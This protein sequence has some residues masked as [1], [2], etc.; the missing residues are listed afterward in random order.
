MSP[1]CAV[2]TL[3]LNPAVDL[4][5]SIPR[6]L[7]GQVHRVAAGRTVAG[8]KGINV[9]AHLADLGIGVAAT[10]FLGTDN[11]ARFEELLRRKGIDERFVRIPGSTRQCIQIVDEISG[12]TTD[13]N[14]PGLSP[15]PDAVAQLEAVIA[16]LVRPGRWF[17]LS[18]S[19]P[20]GMTPDIYARLTR[21]IRSSGG[22]VAV[23]TSGQPL[24]EALL[25]SPDILK[26]NVA[27]LEQLT[28]D[29]PETSVD[30]AEVASSLQSRGVALVV[31]SMGESGA[32]F[33][34]KDAVVL[35]RPPKVS[36]QCTTGAGDAMVSGV[37]YSQMK[38]HT[39]EACAR[40]ATALGT[41]AVVLH[42]GD[43]DRLRLEAYSAQVI[44]ET[45]TTRRRAR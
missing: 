19:V 5:I 4:T 24:R 37:L 36:V 22:R 32:V 41:Y 3:S 13:I 40:F 16:S 8:G 20:Q 12:Q 42:H 34:D 10:G 39:L 30:I 27:E 11:A 45:M 28:G 29:R 25:A 43:L 26:P 2:V 9:A 17:V 14:F 38:N 15:L 33:A 18:G 35:A 21:V 6:F 7:P 44:V 31:V 23:D 1:S